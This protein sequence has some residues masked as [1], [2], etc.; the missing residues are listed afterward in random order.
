MGDNGWMRGSWIAMIVALTGCDRAF[1]L[2]RETLAPGDWAAVAT[3]DRH[4]CGI[5][6]DGS[7]WCWGANDADQLGILNLDESAPRQIGDA[8]WSSISSSHNNTCAIQE[9]GSLWCWGENY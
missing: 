4:T 3:G 7:L 1:G 8:R 6:L 9:D 5:R 2:E